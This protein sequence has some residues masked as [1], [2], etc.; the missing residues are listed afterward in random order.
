MNNKKV[1]ILTLFT[2]IGIIVLPTIYKV[3]NRHNNNLI[4]VVEKEILYQAKL[5]YK[6]EKCETKVLLKD[7]YTNNYLKEKLSNPIT[8]KYYNEES[9]VD[10]T[11]NKIN[12]MEWNSLHFIYL[13]FLI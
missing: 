8:K 9:F 10:L 6:E 5:C 7:L 2:I 11:T 1:I 4:K 3:Y 12:L 13:I